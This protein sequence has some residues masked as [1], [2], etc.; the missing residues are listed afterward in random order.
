MALV[1]HLTCQLSQACPLNCSCKWKSG[2]QAVECLYRDLITIP[3]GID[4]G[5]QILDMAGNILRTLPRERFQRMGL[6]NLQKIFLSRCRIDLVD[7][8]AF[9]GLLNLVEIDLSYNQIELIPSEAFRDF[10]SLMRLNFANNPIVIIESG[11]FR[12]LPYL[13]NLDLNACRIET[14]EEDAFAGLDRIEWIKLE[15]NL[16][17]TIRGA[18]T[19]PNNLHGLDLHNNPWICDCWLLELR[20]WLISSRVPMAIDIQCIAP[21]RLKG[22]DVKTLDPK[23]LACLPDVAPTTLY[24]EIAEGKNVSLLCRVSAIPEA[25]VTWWFQVILIL[26]FTKY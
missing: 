7:D 19:L 6:L 20:G 22:K 2:K 9:R 23:E 15:G 12:L 10:P 25:R 13:T 1:G 17:S 16:L 4:P 3:D 26:F 8:R 24:L 5:T 11:S 14:I 21:E 18:S